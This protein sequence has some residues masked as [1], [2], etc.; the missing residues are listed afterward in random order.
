MFNITPATF[1]IEDCQYPQNSIIVTSEE[2]E[3]TRTLLRCFPENTSGNRFSAIK[4]IKSVF[5]F[6]VKSAK[7]LVNAVLENPS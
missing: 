4:Y 1:H 5:K 7:T 3:N 6:D 2:L